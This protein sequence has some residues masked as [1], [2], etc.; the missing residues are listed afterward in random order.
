MN[1]N[2]GK[3][4]SKDFDDICS[5]YYQGTSAYSEPET[6][7]IRILAEKTDF[8]LW[9]HYDGY[10]NE[11]IIPWTYDPTQKDYGSTSLNVSYDN[12]TQT[13][14]YE[15]VT[16]KAS[17]NI[18]K[19]SLIDYALNLKSVAIQPAIGVENTAKED[20]LTVCSEHMGYFNEILKLFAQN[21]VLE[22]IQGT[23]STSQLNSDNVTYFTEGLLNFTI[24]NPSYSD[25]SILLNI[26]IPNTE[27]NF[28]FY[29]KQLRDDEEILPVSI[30]I[31][32]METL[33]YTI[34]FTV[35][36]YSQ[37]FESFE[38]IA[39]VYSES[40]YLSS[41]IL[42]LEVPSNDNE[43]LGFIML[44]DWYRS[45][46]HHEGVAIGLVSGL[47]AI[48]LALVIL[49]LF[50]LYKKEPGTEE[51]ESEPGFIHKEIH[52]A[53]NNEDQHVDIRQPIVKNPPPKGQELSSG[54]FNYQPKEEASYNKP[55]PLA[56]IPQPK[57]IVKSQ[58]DNDDVPKIIAMPSEKHKFSIKED[59][60]DDIKPVPIVNIPN[61]PNNNIPKA[62]EVPEH[63]KPHFKEDYLQ[64]TGYPIVVSKAN[65]AIP[66][67]KV[68]P[69]GGFKVPEMPVKK[70]NEPQG[71]IM[72]VPS[73]P[74]I[75]ESKFISPPVIA[76]KGRVEFKSS[77]SDSSGIEILHNPT[78]APRPATKI[79]MQQDFDEDIEIK[80]VIQPSPGQASRPYPVDTYQGHLAVP[81]QGH[82]NEGS[83][84][85]QP[86]PYKENQ[87]IYSS[88]YKYAN[89]SKS[90]S[91]KASKGSSSRKKSSSSSSSSS[92]SNQ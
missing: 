57:T 14:E 54:S 40:G 1:R 32:K 76:S 55:Q 25:I 67:T 83:A 27:E 86:S 26:S 43:N 68:P 21:P 53:K 2:F 64:G 19:G 17:D 69:P 92:S 18:I 63:H 80:K 48:I 89:D 78:N 41:E 35:V 20:I 8:I 6:A 7:G 4:F 72:K 59:D 29:S 5:D 28:T 79:M 52:V 46:G 61:R 65:D 12:I 34:Y 16:I 11:Y 51:E 58:Y 33:A 74:E 66:S 39:Y 31:E 84:T 22:Y 62:V 47:V 85:F 30:K 81:V 24:A 10:G 49:L 87:G 13:L 44:R 42:D 91:S 71:E 75:K 23:L 60:D 70:L 38:A 73:K 77:D 37:S 82:K 45:S 15:N 90:N 3:E 56:N 36:H 9:V 50:C 88:P